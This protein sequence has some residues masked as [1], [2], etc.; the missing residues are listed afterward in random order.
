MEN[1]EK[2]EIDITFYIKYKLLEF[3]WSNE[4]ITNF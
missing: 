1:E 3:G 4:N 2:H